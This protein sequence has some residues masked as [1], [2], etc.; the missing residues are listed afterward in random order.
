MRVDRRILV[1]S[2]A[3]LA[4]PLVAAPKDAISA[5]SAGYRAMGAAYKSV[6]DQLRSGNLDKAS[7]TAAAARIQATAK[8]QY[9]WFPKGSGPEA[10]VKTAAKPEI[11]SQPAQFKA[12]QDAF[13]TQAAAFSKAVASGNTAA[14]T[15]QTKQLGA[16]CSAC[17]KAFRSDAKG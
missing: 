1:L 16:A 12:A 10:G 17:H 4:A 6:N 2:F 3:L 8:A 14:L 9:G 5:R 11:W 7:L 15:A 13:A